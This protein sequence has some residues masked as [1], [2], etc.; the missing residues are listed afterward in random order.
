MNKFENKDSLDFLR[1][2]AKNSV[3][4]GLIDP[5]YIISKASGFSNMG[6][7]GVQNYQR[8]RQSM[9]SGSMKSLSVWMIWKRI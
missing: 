1:S 2:L 3:D 4:L 7:K 5:P 6:Q 9:A 8:I